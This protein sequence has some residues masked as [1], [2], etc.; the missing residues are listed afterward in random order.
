MIEESDRIL[1]KESLSNLNLD[2]DN[3]VGSWQE[4]E[5]HYE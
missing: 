3:L 5:V 4:N 2:I 1:S